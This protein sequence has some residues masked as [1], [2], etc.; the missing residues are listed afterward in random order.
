MR[1]DRHPETLG[2]FHEADRLAVALGPCHAEVVLDAAFG[3]GTFFVADQHDGAAG[4]TAHAADDG[5]V[6][7]EITVTG[8]RREVLDQRRLTKAMQW[9]RSG[10]RATWVFCHGVSLA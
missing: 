10:W 4:E 6:L 5:M 1:D 3:V 2:H 8:Q 9:G 7:G